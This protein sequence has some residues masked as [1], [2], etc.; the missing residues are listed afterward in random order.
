MFNEFLF[1]Y[2][3]VLTSQDTLAELCFAPQVW[4]INVKRFVGGSAPN[5]VR[6]EFCTLQ[7]PHLAIF[8]SQQHATPNRPRAL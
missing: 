7:S 1:Y 8:F 4:G 5:Q 2:F 3:N 6:R